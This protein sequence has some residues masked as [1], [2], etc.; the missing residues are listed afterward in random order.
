MKSIVVATDGSEHGRAAVEAA[1]ERAA[2]AGARLVCV[3]VASVL[4]FTQRANGSAPVPPARVPRAEKD[5]VLREAMEIA[6]SF[7][8]T[9]ESELLVGNTSEQILRFAQAVRAD[10]IV[11][12]T[13]GLGPVKGAVVGSVSRELLAHADRPVL[14]VRA[15]TPQASLQ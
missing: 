13:R 7:G 5:S 15:G 6:G 11:V 14:V 12:G 3:R 2:Q 8:V 10:L 9:A 4:E 1:A